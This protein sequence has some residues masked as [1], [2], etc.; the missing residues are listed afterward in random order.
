MLLVSA[1][2]GTLVKSG[3]ANPWFD[4]PF[5]IFSPRTIISITSPL[6]HSTYN[7]NHLFLTFTI[8]MSEWYQYELPGS[9]SNSFSLSPIEYYLDG[10]LAGKIEGHLSKE[11][12]SLSVPLSGISNGLHSVEIKTTTTGLNWQKTQ[13]SNGTI[14]VHWY[15]APVLDSSGRVYFTVKDPPPIVRV[16]SPENKTY[17]EATIP[18]TFR[19]SKQA[20]R[21]AYSLDGSNNITISENALAR[22]P[23][24][25]IWSGNLTLAGL[26]SGS[27]NLTLYATDNADSTGASEAIYFSMAEEPKEPEESEPFQT[28]SIMASVASVAIV[29]AGLVIYF[30]KRNSKC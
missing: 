23:N 6:D 5:G 2:A 24:A 13:N 10:K 4:V 21:V 15:P 27:H 20:S 22:L 29:G 9:S 1:L 14:S 28:T 19:I 26:S 16:Y 12:Y 7:V 8:D 3:I 30:K 18:L 11:A 17:H 25:S